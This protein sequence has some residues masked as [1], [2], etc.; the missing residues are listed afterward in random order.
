MKNNIFPCLWFDGQG[1]EAA[2]FYTETFKGKI[3]VD[4]PSVVNFEVFGQR[5]M[6]LNAGP[7]FQKNASISFTVICE[8]EE[9]VAN[10]WEH[11]VQNG[12]VLM[13]LKAYDWSKKYGWVKDQYGVTWQLY[14][15][16]VQDDQKIFPNLMFV[17]ENNGK[18]AG[19]VTFYTN[20]FPNSSVGQ[21]LKYG[22][23]VGNETHEIPENVQH[24]HFSIDGYTMF[25]LDSSHPHQFNFNEAISLVVMTDDQLETDHLWNNLISDGGRPSRCGWLKDRYGVSWQ[26]VPKRL[27][28]LMNDPD[29]VKGH[30]VVQSM[31]TMEKIIIDELEQAYNS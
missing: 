22:E 3:T 20:I 29:P 17:G 28:E 24:A 14:L 27:I 9:E 26:I 15:G 18:A 10:Y 31:F 12:K 6:I 30:K 7:Q 19:A 8:T 25:C 21:I 5:F 13:D 2:A 4:T 23:G 16:E 11:L 1:N